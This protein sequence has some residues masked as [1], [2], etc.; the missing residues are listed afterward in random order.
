MLHLPPPPPPPLSLVQAGKDDTLSNPLLW[1]NWSKPM[2][3]PFRCPHTIC[4]MHYNQHSPLVQMSLF[5]QCKHMKHIQKRKG[6]IICH[7]PPPFPTHWKS[8]Y[9]CTLSHCQLEDEAYRVWS[10][11]SSE[12]LH[13]KPITVQGTQSAIKKAVLLKALISRRGHQPTCPQVC[14]YH[15]QVMCCEHNRT[16]S[17]SVSDT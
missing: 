14:F 3:T 8:V 4:C 2:P 9:S 5:K 6:G 7:I 13:T 12:L 10:S 1:Y 17:D 11:T 16:T 15:W